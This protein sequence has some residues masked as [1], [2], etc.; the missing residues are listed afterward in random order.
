MRSYW[1]AH[2]KF[3]VKKEIVAKPDSVFTKYLYTCPTL[4]L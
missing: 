1:P 4:T 3:Q 2:A